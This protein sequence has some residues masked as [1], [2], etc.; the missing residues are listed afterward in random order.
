MLLAVLT[1][2][3][4]RSKKN[5]RKLAVTKL[6][7]EVIS[8]FRPGG[9]GYYKSLRTNT[10]LMKLE[11]QLDVVE[12]S[13][14]TVPDSVYM[15]DPAWGYVEMLKAR[16]SARGHLMAWSEKHAMQEC[17]KELTED[18]NLNRKEYGNGMSPES[19]EIGL[20]KLLEIF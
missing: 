12:Y 19:N 4:T 1:S 16:N 7:M 5:A 13:R 14:T 11:G 18:S 10:A 20:K 9:L 8:Q 15:E 2:R 3:A 6:A 17:L